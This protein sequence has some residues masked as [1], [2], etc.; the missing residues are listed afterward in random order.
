[1]IASLDIM[2]KS[3]QDFKPEEQV[4]E[5]SKGYETEIIELNQAQ[6]YQG[7]DQ[8]KQ[9]IVPSYTPFTVR[10]KKRKG[11]PSNRV[12]LKDT[13][14]FYES[15]KIQYD[16]KQFFIYADDDK[17]RDLLVKYGFDVFGLND[18]S[19]QEVIEILKPELIEEFRNTLL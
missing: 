17:T 10:I 11:Q 15:F 14:D 5:V 4:I 3:V 2:L 18:D 7:T 13:G 9:S 6:I 12:T 16:K 1:M 8:N 19:T